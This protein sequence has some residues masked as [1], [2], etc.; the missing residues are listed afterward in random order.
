M[1]DNYPPRA[2]LTANVSVGFSPLD[3][4]F[5]VDV[6][7]RDGDPVEYRLSFGNG[8]PAIEGTDPGGSATTTFTTPGTY[9]VRLE[10]LDGRARGYDYET[11]TVLEPVPLVADAGG[12]VLAVEDLPVRFYG[13]GSTPREVIQTYQWDFG[14]GATAVRRDR[15][16]HLQRTGRVRGDVDRRCVRVGELVDLQ[17]DGAPDRIRYRTG[18]HRQ[19]QHRQGDSGC[20]RGR[21]T[22]ERTKPHAP[23]RTSAASHRSLGSLMARTAVAVAQTGFLPRIVNTTVTNGSGTLA[24]TLEPAC[25]PRP[26]SRGSA[27]PSKRSSPPGST[28]TT[29][30]TR[31]LRRSRSS[32]R[33]PCTA[34]TTTSTDCAAPAQAAAMA[35][36]AVAAGDSG[37]CYRFTLQHRRKLQRRRQDLGHHLRDTRDDHRHDDSGGGELAQGV[38]Q[39]RTRSVQQRR[40]GLH[41]QGRQR[42]LDIPSGLSLADTAVPQSLT[43]PM[44]N[45]PAGGEV[46]HTWMVRGDEAGEYP[47]SATYRGTLEPTGLPIG[48]LVA[49]TETPLKVW[50]LD[51]IDFLIEADDSLTR[52]SPYHVRVGMKNVSDVPV[53]NARIA[54]G[55]SDG[56]DYWYQ[57]EEDL[58]YTTQEIAPGETFWTDEVI[59]IDSGTSPFSY[60]GNVDVRIAGLAADQYETFEVPVEDAAVLRAES[61]E[62]NVQF[63][64]DPVP[65]ATEYR[66]YTLEDG[67][68]GFGVPDKVVDG[69]I[70]FEYLDDLTPGDDAIYAVA[71]AVDGRLVMLH[72]AI[73]AR[74]Q[75]DACSDRGHHLGFL[76][77]GPTTELSPSN[78]STIQADGTV[79]W[80]AASDAGSVTF[81]VEATGGSATCD[82]DTVDGVSYITCE[83]RV[84]GVESGSLV[85]TASDPLGSSVRTY[86]LEPPPDS[87]GDGV[88]DPSDNCPATSNPNQIDLDN[89]GVGEACFSPDSPQTNDPRNVP[90]GEEAGRAL[91]DVS[92]H[93]RRHDPGFLGRAGRNGGGCPS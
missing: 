84:T 11:I 82:K 75:I 90:P 70:T 83:L 35:A 61:F 42:N 76:W 57:P 58:V 20:D 91:V 3:V 29:R 64:W 71:T 88:A 77:L 73:I 32:F 65:G 2:N 12:D 79:S 23:A 15:H 7:D 60:V 47:I 81:E 9:T 34:S 25:W 17:G 87:D 5:A 19:G 48:P 85:V 41:I 49:T 24:V 51:A 80:A 69:G 39:R 1:S 89:D 13:S 66:L 44:P 93:R 27:R 4:S 10:A 78:C 14:D 18:S 53:Y 55:E 63:D 45:V 74:G 36:A 43:V 8:Q 59:V 52:L 92:R 37:N 33:A 22:P 62:N 72:N 46:Y 26:K 6:S 86:T 40:T 31:T 21:W 30:T 54:F 50:G 38:L 16:A 28:R 68:A 56:T 67:D